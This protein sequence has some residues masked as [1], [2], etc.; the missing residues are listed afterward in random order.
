M[1][2]PDNSSDQ[3]TISIVH[4]SVNQISFPSTVFWFDKVD[5]MLFPHFIGYKAT[6]GFALYPQKFNDSSETYLD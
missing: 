3:R 2:M 6:S 5:L 4:L 1:C